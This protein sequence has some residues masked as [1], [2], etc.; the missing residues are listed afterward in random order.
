MLEQAE[1]KRS[2]ELERAQM[3]SERRAALL[4][5]AIETNRVR[6]D[7]DEVDEDYDPRNRLEA[8]LRRSL[9]DVDAPD[10]ED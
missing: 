2:R 7:F 6:A 3:A 5:K 4:Q 8:E 9:R 1:A 10:A